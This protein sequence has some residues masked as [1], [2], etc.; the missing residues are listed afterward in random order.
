MKLQHCLSLTLVG[1]LILSIQS[2]LIIQSPPELKSQLQSKYPKGIH[3]SVANYG[4]V[5]FGRSISGTI[6]ISTFLENCQYQDLD[7]DAQRSI[8]KIVLS[9]RGD[10]S[11]TK[12]SLNSQK[13]GAKLAIIADN[14][15]YED[16]GSIVMVDDGKGPQVKIPTILINHEVGEMITDFIINKKQPVSLVVSFET[17][18]K[19][20]ADVTLWMNSNDRKS[21]ILIRDLE[22]Y[23]SR[24]S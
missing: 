6:Y 4:D 8:N 22:P 24:I 13:Q 17:S 7:I 2:K 12:K 18:K 5:P 21:Y 9:T 20:I 14:Q 10:C 23:L 1:I 3:Y 16:P 19:P 11:F 15:I